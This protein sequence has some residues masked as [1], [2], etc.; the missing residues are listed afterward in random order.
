LRFLYGLAVVA[1]VVIGLYALLLVFTAAT[2]GIFAV[3]LAVLAAVVA[4]IFYLRRHRPL[5]G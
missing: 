5:P 3:A 4:G 1:L 2:P